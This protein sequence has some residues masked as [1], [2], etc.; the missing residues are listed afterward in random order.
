MAENDRLAMMYAPVSM[1]RN[2]MELALDDLTLGQDGPLRARKRGVEMA[3]E[4][5][6]AALAMFE[7]AG[8]L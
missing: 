6:R 3:A 5:L 2:L 8:R 4:R 1:G 7:A